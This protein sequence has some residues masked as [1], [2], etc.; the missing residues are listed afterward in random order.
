MSVILKSPSG[1]DIQ[2][3]MW[4]WRPTMLLLRQALRLDDE[5]FELL[6][7][8]GVGAQI[9]SSEAGII[10]TFLDD[11]IATFPKD[12]RL[13][14][15]SSVTQEQKGS[16]NFTDADWDR[17]YSAS[18]SWLVSFRDFCKSSSGFVVI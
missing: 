18:Y 4:H 8:N 11:Y 15:N 14:L 17:H 6:Q 1:A 16:P 12:G 13:L 10:A 5:R 3:N 7:V 2:A 9:S